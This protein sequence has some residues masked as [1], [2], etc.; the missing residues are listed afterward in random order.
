MDW[1][2][3]DHNMEFF[4]S[5]PYQNSC[6]A[7]K[8]KCSQNLKLTVHLH[9]HPRPKRHTFMQSLHFRDM[10]LISTSGFCCILVHCVAELIIMWMLAWCI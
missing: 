6:K 8:S 9:P 4:S 7:R 3:K 2:A 10:V 1:T 5:E